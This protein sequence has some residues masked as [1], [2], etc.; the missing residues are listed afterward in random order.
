MHFKYELYLFRQYGRSNI[1]CRAST[2]Q[3][4]PSDTDASVLDLQLFISNDIVS[5]KIMINMTVLILKLSPFLFWMVMFLYGVYISQL[6][7]FA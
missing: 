1:P 5:T 2:L 7:Q 4:N 6:Y 3:K